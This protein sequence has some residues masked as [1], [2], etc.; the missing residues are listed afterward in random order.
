MAITWRNIDNDVTRGVAQLMEAARRSINDSFGTL[1]QTL[2][3]RDQQLKDQWNTGK[4]ANTDAGLDRLAQIK[5]LEELDAFQKAGGVQALR[6]QYGNQVDSDALREAGQ[7]LEGDLIAR[8]TQRNQHADNMQERGERS[9]LNAALAKAYQ[10]NTQEAMGMVT[11]EMIKGREALK[12]IFGVRQDLNKERREDTRINLEGQRVQH[13]AARVRLAQNADSR[14]ADRHGQLMEEGNLRLDELRDDNSDRKALRRLEEDSGE[15]LRQTT[16]QQAAYT[17]AAAKVAKDLGIPVSRSNVPE[18][19]TVEQ[20][21]RL[22]DEML[23]RGM[24]ETLPTTT[25][26]LENWINQKL[27]ENYRLGQVS[28]VAGKLSEELNQ[29]PRLVGSDKKYVERELEAFDQRQA[30]ELAAKEAAIKKIEGMNTFLID[31]SKEFTEQYSQVMER[32][33]QA[34]TD[35]DEREDLTQKVTQV[36]SDGYIIV[37]GEKVPVT[38]SMVSAAVDSAGLYEESW[39][40]TPFITSKPKAFETRLKKLVSSPQY[41]QAFREKEIEYQQAKDALTTS[42]LRQTLNRSLW[43]QKLHDEVG[44]RSGSSGA[45]WARRY[46]QTPR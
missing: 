20:A 19:S 29:G 25:A 42:Q 34:T 16:E 38:P 31:G 17:S 10:G 12:D 7:R 27:S 28:Q 36:L 26:A 32:V 45:E 40:A 18:P 3:T 9:Q 37:D 15:F 5:T 33:K 11:P 13:E 44:A 4:K 43:Q 46:N 1:Q 23:K 21:T 39:G 24:P 8:L 6:Q 2:Q 35:E 14:A 41:L 22:K 30:Q